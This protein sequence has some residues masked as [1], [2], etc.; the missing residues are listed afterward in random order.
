MPPSLW[1]QAQ[2][3]ARTTPTPPCKRQLATCKYRPGRRQSEIQGLQNEILDLVL[4]LQL[5]TQTF[6]TAFNDP[7]FEIRGRTVIEQQQNLIPRF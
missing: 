4:P 5:L 6:R 1:V 2:L 3:A 7:E